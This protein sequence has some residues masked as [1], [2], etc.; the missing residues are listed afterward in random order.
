MRHMSR[1]L[2]PWLLL[3][4]LARPMALP[5]QGGPPPEVRAAIQSIEQML[6]GTDEASL[7]ALMEARVAPRARAVSAACA[8]SARPTPRRCSLGST[9]KCSSQHSSP[10]ETIAYMPRRDPACSATNTAVS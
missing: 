8:K 9:Q 1:R 2:I 3:A 7:K 5:A 4:L 10:S 6:L